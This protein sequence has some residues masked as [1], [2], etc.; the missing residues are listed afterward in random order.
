MKAKFIA[1]AVIVSTFILSAG[2][3]LAARKITTVQGILGESSQGKSMLKATADSDSGYFFDPD[4]AAGK[5]ILSTCQQGKMCVV[6]G[7]VR[8]KTILN[9]YYV[10]VGK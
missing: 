5:K 3:A 4:S 8:G 2:N 1:T 6:R 10:N 9:A 7:V